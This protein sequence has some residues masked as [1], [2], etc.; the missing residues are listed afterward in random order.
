MSSIN[1]TPDNNFKISMRANNI[2]SNFGDNF[3]IDASGTSSLLINTNGF[4][5]ARFNNLG[6]VLEASGNTITTRQ[7][8]NL[9]LDASNSNINFRVN[10]VNETTI[11]SI[12]LIMNSG[13]IITTDQN[14]NLIL[15]ASNSN[16]NFRRNGVQYATMDT[17]FNFTNLPT[18]SAAPSTST[19]LVNK[20]YVDSSCCTGVYSSFLQSSA[21][22]IVINANSFTYLFQTAI[23]QSGIY[24]VLVNLRIYYASTDLNYYTCLLA[25]NNTANSSAGEI[26]TSGS[27]TRRLMIAEKLGS[28]GS[29]FSNITF[30]G[31]W[32]IDA[33]TGFSY[34]GNIGVKVN[35]SGTGGG[36]SLSNDPNGWNSIKIIRL[37]STS[38]SGTTFY[39]LGG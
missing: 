10:G 2:T 17:S 7:N 14:T 26:T 39:I 31:T 34:P 28:S 24:L 32:I 3:T 37:G 5:R 38:T 1:I 16:I 9:I 25:A 35:A 22:T 11:S 19:Q 21:G 20:T 8:S 29:G 33:P 6:L 13:A 18:C 36:S 12:G 30:T 4:S 15:D 23:S 27:S